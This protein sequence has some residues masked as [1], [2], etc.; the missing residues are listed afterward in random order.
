MG[1]QQENKSARKQKQ[2]IKTDADMG[3]LDSEL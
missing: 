3:V 1:R 2:I